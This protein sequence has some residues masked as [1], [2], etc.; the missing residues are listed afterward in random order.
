MIRV[1]KVLRNEMTPSTKTEAEATGLTRFFTG[2]PCRRGHLS[3]RY[4][5]TGACAECLG[6]RPSAPQAVEDEFRTKF[7]AAHDAYQAQRASLKM[8]LLDRDASMSKRADLKRELIE[9]DLA[10]KQ[11]VQKLRAEAQVR[12]AALHPNAKVPAD[13]TEWRTAQAD[14]KRATRRVEKALLAFHKRS[15]LYGS[16]AMGDRK[17]DGYYRRSLYEEVQLQVKYARKVAQS[18]PNGTNWTRAF[19]EHHAATVQL[20]IERILPWPIDDQG[21]MPKT[22]EMERGI[23]RLRALREARDKAEQVMRDRMPDPVVFPAVMFDDVGE[24]RDVMQYA[25]GFNKVMRLLDAEAPDVLTTPQITEKHFDA[26]E[27]IKA[28][29]PRMQWK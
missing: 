26:L 9:A 16:A 6:V 5:S 15:S 2:R 21:G 20:A 14:L 11:A 13:A 24:V 3:E 28:K 1:P 19:H 22:R 7:A 17:G 12:V 27:M 23:A 18:D 10:Y 25:D 29:L 8:A 4:T